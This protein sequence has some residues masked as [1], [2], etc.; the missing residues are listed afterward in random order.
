MYLYIVFFFLFFYSPSNIQFSTQVIFLINFCLKENLDFPLSLSFQ[1]RLRQKTQ[2][3]IDERLK[4]K[5]D[6][7]KKYKQ[8][9]LKTQQKDATV[10]S[11]LISN[12][13]YSNSENPFKTSG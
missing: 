11:G 7:I 13:V 9:Q 10:D 6:R 1:S 3:K 5:S 4:K 2:E 8:D 12:D